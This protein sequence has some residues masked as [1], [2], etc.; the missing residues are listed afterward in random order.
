MV[1]LLLRDLRNGL[2]LSDIFVVLELSSAHLSECL[3][4]SL[5]LLLGLGNVKEPLS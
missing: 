1:C 4:V 3:D 2:L 5:S